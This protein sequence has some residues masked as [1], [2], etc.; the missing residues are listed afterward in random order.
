MLDTV[1]TAEAPEG[2]ALRLR[3]AGLSARVLAFLVDALI[4]FALWLVLAT[5]VAGLG[6]LGRMLLLV[7]LFLLEWFYPVLFELLPGSAT[8][9]KRLLGLQVL[10]DD[11]LPVTP[12]ASLL[13]NLLRGADFLPFGYAAGLLS[14]LLRRDFKRLGDIAA[15]TLVVHARAPAPIA[16]QPETAAVAPARPLTPR[17]QAVILAWAAR[18]PRLTPERADEL[19]AMASAAWGGTP[20][21]AQPA[22]RLHGIAAWLM[23]QR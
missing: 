2:I 16:R 4:R 20:Q 7:G 12:G 3:P 23:G 22:Q 13:R 5:V 19:A 9:G 11:G 15:G 8:P 6:G 1:A 14:M 17:E 18:A 21:D 10:M